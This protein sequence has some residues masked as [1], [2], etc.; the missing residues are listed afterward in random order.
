MNSLI[1][2]LAR[3]ERGDDQRDFPL[4]ASGEVFLKPVVGLVNDEVDGE[5]RRGGDAVEF[6][7]DALQPL[8]ELRRRPCVKGREAAEDARLALR[9]HQVRPRHDEHRRGDHGQPQVLE[10]C[11]QGHWRIHLIARLN[12]P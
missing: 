5:G 10:R 12:W 1:D 7:G 3:A 4:R 9:D 11:G 8:V 6:R 2:V